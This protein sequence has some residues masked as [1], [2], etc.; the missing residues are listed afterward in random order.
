MQGQSIPWTEGTW[1]HTPA[2]VEVDGSDLVVTAV[3]G[4]DAWRITSY[5]FVHESEHALIR[6]L[7]TDTAVEV[8]FTVDLR[9]QFDQA[10]IFLRASSEH[11]VKAGVEYADGLPQL[12]VVVTDGRSDWSAFPVPTWSRRRATIR[13]SRSG[14]AITI[15]AKVDEHA[16]QFVRLLPFD[17]DV[18]LDAGPFLCAP[19][20]AG[21]TVRFHSWRTT[22]PDTALH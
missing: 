2:H 1:T 17:P 18:E 20:R 11:W 22:A 6:P 8:Q 3:E 13:A 12:G 5:G 21:L 15:R 10:G 4:S 9:E 19:T 14:D 7:A 16:L